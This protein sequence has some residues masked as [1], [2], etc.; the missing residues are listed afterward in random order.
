MDDELRADMGEQQDELAVSSTPHATTRGTTLTEDE[1]GY[2]SKR[3]LIRVY[4]LISRQ[5][6]QIERL[7]I[8]NL[9]LLIVVIIESILVGYLIYIII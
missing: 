5:Q 4:N 1:M 7:S 2:A 6:D 9:I 3:D 8:I